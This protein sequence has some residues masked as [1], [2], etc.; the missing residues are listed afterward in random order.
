[1]TQ[2]TDLSETDVARLTGLL[3]AN[4]V[5]ALLRNIHNETRVGN[6][7]WAPSRRGE[8][9]S[10]G[11]SLA[12][13]VIN[14]SRLSQKQV[15]AAKAIVLQRN[16]RQVVHVIANRLVQVDE[17]ILERSLDRTGTIPTY[18][19]ARGAGVQVAQA[20]RL[21]PVADVVA[22]PLRPTPAPAPVAV[23]GKTLAY[24]RDTC[25][26]PKGHRG[27]CAGNARNAPQGPAQAVEDTLA[28]SPLGRQP[29]A[30]VLPKVKP[31]PE[32]DPS[33]DPSIQR[34][35]RLDLEDA[36]DHAPLE[37]TDASVERFKLLDLD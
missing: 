37:A 7:Q 18:S 29:A 24:S 28:S 35:Q 33:Q 25:T 22:R 1:M 36:P 26:S 32:P 13:Q 12:R 10:F 21:Q 5:R 8:P 30:V 17:S 9:D 2:A 20:P 3:T 4:Q 11:P 15:S 31:L 14:G 27:A 19:R 23:C 16:W 34:F 6:I